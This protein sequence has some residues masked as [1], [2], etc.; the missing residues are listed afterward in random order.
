M[1]TLARLREV[2]DYKPETG[3]FV[4]KIPAGRW[5]RIPAGTV[6]GVLSGKYLRI[7]LDGVLYHAHRLAIFHETGEWPSGDV[8]HRDGHAN[9]RHNLRPCSHS[10]NMANAR[11]RSDNTTGFKGVSRAHEC[12]RFVAHAAKRYVGIFDSPQAAAR[13][14]DAAAIQLWGEFALTNQKLGLLA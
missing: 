5:G 14:Y 10:Q 7:R 11:M 2:L 12:D 1:L 13:A 4:W 8:D 6:A 9:A 3:M